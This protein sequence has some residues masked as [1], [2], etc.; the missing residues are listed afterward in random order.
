M[1]LVFLLPQSLDDPSGSGRYWP[2]AKELARLGHDVTMLCLHPDL[3]HCRPPTFTREG[4][5]VQYVAQMHVRK[6]GG[7]KSYFPA[8][9]LPWVAVRGAMSMA[10]A[11]RQTEADACFIAK[12]QPINSLA[13]LSQPRWWRAGR[14]HLDSDDYEAGSNNFQGA[15]QRRLVA[16]VEDSVSRSA[17]VITTNT[18]FTAHRLGRLGVPTERVFIVPNGVDRDRVRSVPEALP[19][20]LRQRHGLQDHPLMVYVGS[21]SLANHALD[22]LLAAMA[23]A[24]RHRPDLRLAIVGGGEDCQRLKEMASNLDLAE[25][26]LFVG[27]VD[28]VEALAWLGAAD[29]A[30]D[31]ARDDPA[32]QARAPLKLVEAMAMSTPCLTADVGDRMATLGGGEAGYL[33]PAGDPEAMAAGLLTALAHPDELRAK[34]M[35][36][37]R[38]SEGFYWD[39]LVHGCVEAHQLS[40]P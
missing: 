21:L 36:A 28:P 1:R 39:E 31:P 35:A 11:L 23:L 20:E 9:K 8:W 10:Q 30:V 15:W 29:L 7:T 26:V 37:T 2:L 4:V 25:P 18:S 19:G 24:C 34:K 12:A 32:H 14:V 3:A 13:S 33:V 22:L 38:I 5:R 17:S 6:S 40:Q 27:R 16:A